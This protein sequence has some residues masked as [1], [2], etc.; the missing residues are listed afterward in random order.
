MHLEMSPVMAA[1]VHPH[2]RGDDRGMH[3][4]MVS[5]DGSPP[6]AW[7]R[8]HD[9]AEVTVDVRFTPTRVGTIS[10]EKATIDC[11]SVHPHARGD[12]VGFVQTVR[13]DSGSP[14]RAWGRS[15]ARSSRAIK[16][17][18]TPTR[19]G[20]IRGSGG[21]GRQQAVHPHARGDDGTHER[22]A[23]RYFGSPPRAWGR[24][25]VGGTRPRR[26]RFTPTRVGTMTVST[27]SPRSAPVHP[28]ARGDD[29]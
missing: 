20:T 24:C 6:R 2:A 14:P 7:G 3:G 29:L 19:V 28:H 27:C 12:D 16:S 5:P 8:L 17:R 13:G 26:R 22:L 10:N 18:F 9:V 23:P 25:R 11:R 4:I 21:T 1:T 15:D